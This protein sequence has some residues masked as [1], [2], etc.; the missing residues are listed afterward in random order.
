MDLRRD[1]RAGVEIDRVLRLVGKMGAT[2]LH[3]GNLRLGIGGAGPFGI[4]GPL[5]LARP[6]E[7]LKLSRRGRFDPALLGHPPQH[8][9]VALAGVPPADRAHR[10][11]GLHGRG[12][13]PDPLALDQAVLGEPL[14]HP[15]EH[16]LVHFQ[17]QPRPGPAQPGMVRHPLVEPEAEE[18]P[19]REAVGAAPFQP[20]LA[21]DPLEVA[22]QMHPEVPPRRQRRRPQPR[23]IE[24][25]TER[26]GEG[27]ETG[28]VQNPLQLVIE[29]VAGRPRQ[30]VPQHHH[31]I[32]PRALPTHRHGWPSPPLFYRKRISR[33]PDFVNGLLSCSQSS[34]WAR[35]RVSGRCR[36]R[37]GEWRK[38]W[39]AAGCRDGG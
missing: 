32:L 26:L 2:I 37:L 4:R 10:G 8:L 38:A 36:S 39:W 7:L 31:L 29:D 3:P 34:P 14:Q 9:A 11:V 1:H 24:R 18:V 23:R 15:G 22:D 33:Q 5:A 16:L 35:R 19:Q 30:L 17:R 28:L 6:V 27:V 13:D 12:I 21:R 25:L 20:A